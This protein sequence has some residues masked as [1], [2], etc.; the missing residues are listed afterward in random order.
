V[1]GLVDSAIAFF[2]CATAFGE[3]SPSSMGYGLFSLGICCL[4]AIVFLVNCRLVLFVTHF[5]WV[6]AL[7]FVL[8]FLVYFG[9][10]LL[11]SISSNTGRDQSMYYVSVNTLALPTFWLAVLLCVVM[12]LV[13]EWAWLTLREQPDTVLINRMEKQKRQREIN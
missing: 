9:F 4:T 10:L 13:F 11:V 1:R 8:T 3:D 5:T 7:S 12:G 6:L 2:V